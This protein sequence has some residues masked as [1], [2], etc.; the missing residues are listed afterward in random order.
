M[1][2][3]PDGTVPE[4][5]PH[6]MVC[7]TANPAA[8]GLKMRIEDDRVYGTM[9]L[10]RRHEGA[11]GFAHGGAIAAALDD[12]LGTVL[13]LLEQPAVT[14]SLTVDYRAPAVLG[15]ELTL[16][17][18]AVSVEGR[19]LHLRGEVYDGQQLVAEGRAL[20]LAVD[21]AHFRSSGQP[22]PDA[23][24]AWGQREDPAQP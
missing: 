8:I 5:Q 21:L 23:W 4:H 6:C 10:D 15:R 3:A 24:A 1:R 7:G 18:W 17:G 12:L 13:I 11:P 9:C 2:P 19:K 16:T 14:A 22:L 20:F